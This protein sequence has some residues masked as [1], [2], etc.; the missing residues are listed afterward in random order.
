MCNRIQVENVGL[1]GLFRKILN[2]HNVQRNIVHRQVFNTVT[3][4]KRM[5]YTQHCNNDT[6]S[7]LS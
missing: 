7:W 1:L 3:G 2:L 6:S 4:C 5:D